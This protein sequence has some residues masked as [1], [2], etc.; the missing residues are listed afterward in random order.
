MIRYWGWSVTRD[1]PLLGM[2][3][4]WGWS[5]TAEVTVLYSMYYLATMR[6]ISGISVAL[7]MLLFVTM[8]TCQGEDYDVPEAPE[9]MEFMPWPMAIDEFRAHVSTYYQTWLTHWYN[10]QIRER[11]PVC[12]SVRFINVSLKIKP[13]YHITNIVPTGI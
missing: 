9:G 1:D 5:V 2:I 8:A 3:R 4:Y 13:F 12:L 7:V 10:P 6:Q 11:T